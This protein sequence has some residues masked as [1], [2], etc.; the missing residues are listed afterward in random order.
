MFVVVE[1]AD[2]SGKTTLVGESRKTGR[3]VVV[4]T[5]S[6]PTDFRTIVQSLYWMQTYPSECYLIADRIA[7]I[8]ERVYG[9]VLRGVNLLHGHPLEFGLSKVDAIVYCRT[10]TPVLTNQTQLEGVE[11]NYLAIQKAYDDLME[12][13]AEELDIPVF[14]YDYTKTKASSVWSRVLSGVD[15]R[16][17][18]ETNLRRDIGHEAQEAKADYKIREEACLVS[19]IGGICYLET[20]HKGP[21]QY[22]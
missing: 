17:T 19:G 2:G 11:Q 7:S 15:P 6:G 9:P 5:R 1:G 18:T 20:G 8:S 10:E 16:P 4:V 13:I 12:R 21:H 22:R 3:S 14:L